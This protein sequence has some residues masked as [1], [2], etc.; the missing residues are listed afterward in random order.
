MAYQFIDGYFAQFPTLRIAATRAVLT[1]TAPPLADVPSPPS[2]RTS[3]PV[4]PAL[5]PE[6]IR[7]A[8]PDPLVHELGRLAVEALLQQTHQRVVLRVVYAQQLVAAGRWR[9]CGF[10]FWQHVGED[11]WNTLLASSLRMHQ[12]GCD[13]TEQPE[14]QAERHQLKGTHVTDGMQDELSRF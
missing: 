9:G 1:T 13:A 11:R 10:L 7:I 12:P 6:A 14:C 3:P 5:R 4:A 8:P 2:M